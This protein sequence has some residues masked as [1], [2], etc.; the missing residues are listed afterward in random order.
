MNKLA[1]YQ[2]FFPIGVLSSLIA[3]GIWPFH[4]MGLFEAPVMLIH[5]RLIVGGFIWSFIIGFL[6]AAIPK[7]SGTRNANKFEVLLALALIS[8]QIEV[9]N[10]RIKN[11]SKQ[12][13][14]IAKSSK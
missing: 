11:F 10:T 3:V 13:L 9:M 14:V 6:L 4:T 7:M 2:I 1:P 8:T 12:L 5:S